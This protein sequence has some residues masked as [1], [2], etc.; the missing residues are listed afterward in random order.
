LQHWRHGRYGWRQALQ[1]SPIEMAVSMNVPPIQL[2]VGFVFHF[3]F[4]VF[5]NT[6]N[7]K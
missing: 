4:F 3:F 6:I 5:L 7:T 1:L 2:A